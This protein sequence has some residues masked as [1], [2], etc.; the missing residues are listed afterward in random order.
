MNC[1]KK[2]D[3]MLV[4]LNLKKM[5]LFSSWLHFVFAKVQSKT[6]ATAL[7]SKN[8]I[9]TTNDL[10]L[11]TNYSCYNSPLKARPKRYF[12]P[13]IRQKFE[14]VSNQSKF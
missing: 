13:I 6:R 14:S 4:Q 3:T 12:C 11:H 5:M 7:Y 9:L 10:P 8:Q 2:A 1:Q